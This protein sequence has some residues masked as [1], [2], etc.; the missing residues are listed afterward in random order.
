M[1][2][3]GARL[4]GTAVET[5]EQFLGELPAIADLSSRRMFGGVGVFAEGKMFAI[6]DSGGFSFY[7]RTKRPRGTSK[8]VVG[9]NTVGC[10]TGRFQTQLYRNST[11]SPGGQPVPWK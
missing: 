11:N 5:A 8:P 7:E 3:K 9:T 2:E 1:G 10:P 6:V 4:T